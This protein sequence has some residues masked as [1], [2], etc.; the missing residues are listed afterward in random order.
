MQLKKKYLILL[1]L[2][3]SARLVWAGG[4]DTLQGKKGL[5][6]P[7]IGAGF[8]MMSY[9]G[10]TGDPALVH[11]GQLAG[12]RTAYHFTA[13]ERLS[14][15]MAI[16][17]NA[18]FGHL[19]GNDRTLSDNRNFETKISQYGLDIVFPFDNGIIM[20]K[21][22]MMVPYLSLGLGMLSYRPYCDSLDSK[23]HPYYYWNDGSIRNLPQGTPG[24]TIETRTYNYSIP[25]SGPKSALSI[26]FGFGFRIIMTEHLS[27]RVNCAY[28]YVLAKDVDG[29]QGAKS[30][31]R[32]M[33]INVSLHYHFGKT[34]EEADNNKNYEK[35]DWT[36]IEN[37][38]SDGD[39]VKDSD[40]RCPGTPKGVA[41]DEHGCPLDSDGDGVPDY[42]DLEPNTKK[43]AKVDE[44]G[45]KLDFKKIAEHQK[46]LAHYDSIYAARSR[47]FNNAPSR[48]AA[49]K[50]EQG[51]GQT[52]NAPKKQMPADFRELDK[53]FDGII[54][55]SEVTSA[56]DGFFSGENSL[57]VD[58]IN[59]LIDFF[60]EQ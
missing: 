35:V 50:I 53:N 37:M 38:D 15:F 20:K 18:T 1:L 9:Y 27:S 47:A 25:L 36:E 19:A 56:I 46:L 48:E 14:K 28:N 26:P 44:H 7:S 22:A 10:S 60:F 40:D 43:G 6:L 23:G 59:K 51:F 41:V 2:L 12:V 4:G 21:G 45:V 31:D 55:A 11:A 5:E 30:N 58:K 34:K 16:G 33:Y 17:L 42:L 24:A 29:N 52:N 8:G 3:A 49:E 32:Y 54:S 57:T 13:E 39:G